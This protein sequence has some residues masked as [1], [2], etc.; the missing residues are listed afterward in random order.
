MTTATHATLR[1]GASDGWVP[2]ITDLL[3]HALERMDAITPDQLRGLSWSA[4]HSRYR[5]IIKNYLSSFPLVKLPV[6]SGTHPRGAPKYDWQDLTSPKYNEYARV[7]DIDSNIVS[8]GIQKL[9]CTLFPSELR[10]CNNDWAAVVRS[11]VQPAGQAPPNIDR[12]RLNDTLVK[13]TRKAEAKAKRKAKRKA[14][15]K[16]E[17]VRFIK[18]R[19]VARKAVRK[20]W[21]KYLVKKQTN[22]NGELFCADCRRTTSPKGAPFVPKKFVCDHKV[23]ICLWPQKVVDDKAVYLPGL[24]RPKNLQLLCGCCDKDKTAQDIAEYHARKAA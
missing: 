23:A 5:L 6:V 7:K 12:L 15:R 20:R 9:A 17:V 14:A 8:C 4:S 22:E 1:P 10:A 2:S 18:A 24:N 11:L 21:L 13:A 3:P 16:E 19:R